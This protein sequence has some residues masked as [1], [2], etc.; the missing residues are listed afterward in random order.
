MFYIIFDL[1]MSVVM[2]LFGIWFYRSA[3]KAA[4]FLSGY[5]MKPED[6]RKNMM[7]KVCARLMEKEYY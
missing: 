1:L 5:N 7:K 6:E 2:L 3:G 4:K